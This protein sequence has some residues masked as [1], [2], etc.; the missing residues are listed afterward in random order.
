MPLTDFKLGEVEPCLDRL[1]SISIK[2]AGKEIYQ[3]N[4]FEMVKYEKKH[5]FEWGE[6]HMVRDLPKLKGSC[7]MDANTGKYHDD[8]YID[9]CKNPLSRRRRNLQFGMASL[10][11]KTEDQPVDETN[12]DICQMNLGLLQKES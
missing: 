6:Y 3:D 10:K 1:E 2:D 4:E 7:H 12:D 11:K 5:T 9:L 8:R